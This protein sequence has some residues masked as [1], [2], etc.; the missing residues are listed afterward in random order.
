[1]NKQSKK[2]VLISGGAGKMGTLI[3]D[4]VSSQDNLSLIHI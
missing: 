3:I 1:M 2:T 4:Y